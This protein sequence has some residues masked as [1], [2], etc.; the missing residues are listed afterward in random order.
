[1]TESAAPAPNNRKFLFISPLENPVVVWID[2]D[3][4]CAIPVC[5]GGDHHLYVD[6]FGR[7]WAFRCPVSLSKGEQG[8]VFWDQPPGTARQQ[9][10]EYRER[11]LQQRKERPATRRSRLAADVEDQ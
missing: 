5:K 6:E 2:D 4:T 11:L 7:K 1:M 9:I 3:G 8:Q 10:R